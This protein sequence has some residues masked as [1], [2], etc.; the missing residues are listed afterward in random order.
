M[1][2]GCN[3]GGFLIRTVKV[4]QLA[5]YLRCM[6]TNAR[7]LGNKQEELEV[8]AESRNYDVIGITETWWGSLHDLSTVMDGYKLFRKDRQGRKGTG[9]A[10][11]VKE[12]YDCSELQDET[13]EKPLESFGVKFRGESKGDV[14]AG[15]CYRPPDQEDEVDEEREVSRSQSLVLMEDFNHPDICWESNTAV[16]RQSRKFLECVRD[17]FLME[18]LEEPTRGHA[19]LDLLLTNKGEFV[20]E[21]EAG[22]SLGGSDHEIVELRILTKG[23]MESSKICTLDFRKADFDSLRELMGRI[24]WEA[25]MRGKGV[26]ESWLY[27]KEALLRAQ[28]QTI[29]MCKQN[30]KYGK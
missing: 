23:R 10:L 9:V 12:Q 3:R 13:G 5:S 1:Q 17:N 24:P 26:Q 19:P 11:C 27:F 7:S 8:L 28:E 20:G 4:G 22:G 25:N 2:G 18:V 16:H 6:Y 15:V 14:V 29:P 30:S 21:V